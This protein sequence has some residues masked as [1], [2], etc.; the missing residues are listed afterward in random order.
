MFFLF[1]FIQNSFFSF[2]FFRQSFL[3]IQGKISLKFEL[4]IS[5]NVGGDRF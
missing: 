4:V 3:N 1:I 2:N 5:K